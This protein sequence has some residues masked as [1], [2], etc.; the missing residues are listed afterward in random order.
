M[1]LRDLKIKTKLAITFVIV[2][3][4]LVAGEVIALHFLN[5]RLRSSAELELTNIVDHLHRL[6]VSES[7]LAAEETG[8]GHATSRTGHEARMRKLV[9][10]FSVGKTGY[11]FVMDSR[12]RLLA[13]P[14]VEGQSILDRRDSDGFA[15]I[16]AICERAVKLG[17]DEVG[18]IRYPWH[19]GDEEPR[20]KIL[21]FRY[22]EP[23]DWIIAAGSYEDEI[24]DSL[25]TLRMGAALLAAMTLALVILLTVA[26][27][28][29]I[30]RPVGQLSVM[31]GRLASGDLDFRVAVD[32]GDEFGELAA[33]FGTMADEVRHKREHL[34]QLVSARTEELRASRE[35]YRRLVESTV[36]AI[37]TTDLHGKITFVNKGFESIVGISREEA[38][39]K[40]ISNFYKGGLGLAH[41]IMAELHQ[42][43]SIGSREMEFIWHERRIPIRTSA[44]IL[45]DGDGNAVG[46]LGVFSDLTEQR[47]LEAELGRAQAELVQT[48][49]LRALGDMVAGVAHEVNNPLMA[50]TT[51]LHVMRGANCQQECPNQKRMA[52][53]QRCN[54]RIAR[55]VDHLRDFS[56]Q[57]TVQFEPIDINAP[58][59]GALLI[60]GQQLLDMQMEI[61]RDLDEHLPK[62]MADPNQ[63]EQVLLDLVANARDAMEGQERRVLRLSTGRAELSGDE[64][65]EIRITDTGPGIPE[66]VRDKIF[67]P[68][69]TTKEAGKGTGLG[70]AICYGIIDKHGGTIEALPSD[71]GGATFRIVLPVRGP[72]SMAVPETQEA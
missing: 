3:L 61:E 43:G 25:E 23:W 72:R 38:L 37:V 66:D 32:T 6:A 64:A 11:A 10:S 51:I 42:H 4:P 45:E 56:R 27:T 20:Q 35:Q 70:L 22:F 53:L 17:P 26:M 7:R 49:K 13:H 18:T 71:E 36:D 62:V 50:S 12:G 33:A 41:E 69:F 16:Q 24:Y 44:S 65:V 31:A 19:V 57:S 5:T 54:E 46:T 67:E 68:F 2:V 15:F 60:T 1:R 39:G 63:I 14:H 34:S 8:A 52:L 48:M 59:T 28:R 29:L 21:K 30:T 55:I 40:R 58:V 9:R 47:K